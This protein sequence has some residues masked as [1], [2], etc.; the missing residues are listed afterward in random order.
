MAHQ[1]LLHRWFEEVWNEGREEAIDEMLA[2]NGVVNGLTDENGN[3]IVGP[4]MFK[5][6]FHRFRAAFPDIH[7]TIE[8]TVCEGNMIT[9]FCRV[10]G[11]H[12]GEGIGVKPTNQPIEFTGI[13]IIKV[14]DGKIVEAWNQFDFMSMYGQLGVLNLTLDV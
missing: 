2:E 5:P 7:V 3:T 10:M 12:A 8:R 9:G 11:T 14:E 6:F 4:A 13:A 1:T